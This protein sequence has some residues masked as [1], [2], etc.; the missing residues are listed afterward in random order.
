MVDVFISYRRAQR[1]RAE[2]IREKLEALGL[3]VFFDIQGIDGGADFPN[4]IDHNLRD[5][6]VILACWSELYFERRPAPDW[7]MIE[8]RFGLR[9]GTL[10]PVA[11]ERFESDSPP[12][13][14]HSVNYFDLSDWR[15]ADDHEDWIRTLSALSRHLGRN[16]VTDALDS[17]RTP[18]AFVTRGDAQVAHKEYDDAIAS[19]TEAIKLDPRD[20]ITFNKRGGAYYLEQRLDEAASDYSEAI[21]INPQYASALYNRG[22]V[23]DRQRR[24]DAAIIDYSEA[25]RF[26]PEAAHAY[27]RRASDYRALN[28]YARA[29]A[30][31]TE[32]IRLEPQDAYAY[33]D[34]ADA[35]LRQGDFDRAVADYTEAM[36]LE[37]QEAAYVIWRGIAFRTKKDYA[38]AIADF[39][40][41]MRI[42]PVAIDPYEERGIAYREQQDYARAI[43]DFDE[44]IRRSPEGTGK[45]YL[46]ERGLTHHER[47]DFRAAIAD[48]TEALADF[49]DRIENS[50]AQSATCGS[51]AKIFTYRAQSHRAL[52]NAA[53]A[54][55][56]EEQAR[57]LTARAEQAK[58]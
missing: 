20:A 38:R 37:P 45:F 41:A 5:A 58:R 9:K 19:Y 16:I 15:C 48:Y 2:L 17:T 14:L 42:A 52:G 47:G 13:D 23:Y 56:D 1:S 57:R 4:V 26:N 49:A 18:L 10:V 31:W 51:Y 12:V 46:T 44:A 34:R 33:T 53:F 36:R 35:Y 55:A 6:K 43:A 30:D 50:R 25:I 3:E 28:D 32:A 54:E 11:I 40:E 27:R 39:D 22:L 21:R 24:Y 7:C 8:C 29:I